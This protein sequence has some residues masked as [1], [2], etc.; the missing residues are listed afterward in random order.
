[1]TNPNHID[2]KSFA[3]V[4]KAFQQTDRWLKPPPVGLA[5][6]TKVNYGHTFKLA[7][8]PDALGAV[9]VSEIRP[10][11]VQA[12][13]DQF[14]DRPAQ[15]KCAQTAFKALEKWAVV[16][17][18]LPRPI[19]TGTEAPG[20]TGANEPWTDEHVRLAETH[21]RQ[22]LSRLVTLAANTGQRGSDLT[23]MRWSDIEEYGGHPGINVITKKTKKV[24]WIPFTQ[25]MIA[26]LQAWGRGVGYLV[27]KPEGG[28]YTRPQLSDTWLRHRRSNEALASLDELELSFHGLRA[29]A[30]IRLRRAGVSRP[31]IADMVG[32]S[33]PM[34]DRYCR[35]SEQRDNAMAA[36]RMMEGTPREQAAVIPFK[37]SP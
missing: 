17:D 3:A 14:A 22:D 33:A 11:L 32:M 15:Q 4:I 13:L 12:F 19:T 36:L 18:L 27:V 28:P 35:R 9:P 26:A 8:H 37:K 10:A 34:V 23:R 7:E 20:G 1:M 16:R 25:E 30:V 21:A 2:P 5:K 6:S 29:T 31:L 24:L